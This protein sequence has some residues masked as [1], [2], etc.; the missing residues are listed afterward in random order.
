MMTTGVFLWIVYGLYLGSRPVIAANIITFGCLAV[1][2]W[3][4]FFT[5]QEVS[6]DKSPREHA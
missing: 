5:K 6:T 1:L 3:A 2:A 4:K